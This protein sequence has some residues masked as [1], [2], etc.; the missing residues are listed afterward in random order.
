MPLGNVL[1]Y[2]LRDV[3]L[4][5]YPTL[6]ADT[7]GSTLVDLPVARTMSFNETEEY[8]DLRGDDA[9]QTSHGQGAQVEWEMESGG[10]SFAAGG[11]ISGATVIESGISPNQIK[12]LRKKSTDQRPF[13]TAIGMSV[14]DN[15]GDFQ[16]LIWRAR[17]TGNLE[18]ELGDGQF[19]I[20]SAS[21]IGFPCKV[22]GMVGGMEVLDSVYDFIQRETVG[23][24]AAPTID[25]PAVPQVYSL[26]DV[27]GPTAGGEI[28]VVT[29][30]GF[31]NATAVTVGGTAA[32]DYEIRSNTQ[33]VLITPAK[34]A[35]PHQVVV[36]NP[37]GASTTGAQTTYTYS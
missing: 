13:F 1:P 7:F 28:V 37:T 2:G 19:L 16:G 3:K 6:A 34:T 33:I 18:H 8:E 25:T 23:A 31:S 12:R 36:T 14:S 29:G 22:S 27:A 26:S 32:T 17:A 15:G 24:I 35:G 11:V 5:Q 10:M 20:P 9:L 30:Y 4:I 21:G